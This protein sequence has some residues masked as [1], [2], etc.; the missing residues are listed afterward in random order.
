MQE[1]C[2]GKA[3]VCIVNK[4]VPPARLGKSLDLPLSVHRFE[5]F[6]WPAAFYLILKYDAEASL[7]EVP[8][9]ASS[10]SIHAPLPDQSLKT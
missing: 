1:Y 5:F 2:S 6:A 3:R 9:D 10:K 7:F 4:G 8:F